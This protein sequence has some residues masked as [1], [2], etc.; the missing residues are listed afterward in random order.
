LDIDDVAI[1]NIGAD[2]AILNIDDD[3]G[4]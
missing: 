1:L 3:D 4:V 2:G